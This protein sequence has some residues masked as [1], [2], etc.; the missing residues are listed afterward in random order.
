MATDKIVKDI[1]SLEQD[2][3]IELFVI[4]TTGVMQ[5]GEGGI[6][7]WHSG[8]NEL[9]DSVIWQGSEYLALPIEAEGFD[10]ST[11]GVLP[12][13]KLKLANPDGLF[14]ALVT[15]AGDLIGAKII[16]KRTMRKYLDAVNFAAG[17]PTADPNQHYKDDIFYV[18]QKISEN[19]YVIEWEL[20][21]AFDLGDVMVPKRQVIKDACPWKYR[22]AECSY[23][24]VN[25]FDVNDAATTD[26]TK[27][28]CAKRLSS[29]K[30][31]FGE[32]SVLPY[33][34]FPG[35]KRYE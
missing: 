11:K 23:V 7:R 15:M 22:G 18:E 14:S 9:L 13:P 2:A 30:V 29:C 10:V 1:Q 35:A 27:D 16:R 34:G 25:M 33:G 24:G 3:L 19:R 20:V 8:T 26:S 12:R 17:N 21:S 4:D 6:T 31:R 28:V 5:L 32:Q